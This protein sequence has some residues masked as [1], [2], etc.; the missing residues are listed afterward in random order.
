MKS[1]VHL[2]LYKILAISVIFAL[3]W[4]VGGM[5]AQAK[6][7]SYTVVAQRPNDIYAQCLNSGR[8]RTTLDAESGTLR[9]IGTTPGRP[10]PKPASLPANASPEAAAR[11]YLS[12]CGSLLG[13]RN[14]ASELSVIRQKADEQRTTVRFQ[15][16]Y[17]GIPIVGGEVIVQVDGNK[18]IVAVSKEILP[19]VQITTQASISAAQAQENALQAV[20]KKYELALSDLTASEPELWIYN[21]RL[22]GPDE[23][24]TRLVW[25]MEVEPVA[26]MPI[27]EFVLV[28]AQR[29]SV[30]LS[31]NQVDTAKNRQTYTANNTTTLPGTLVC[32]ESNPTCSGGDTHAQ[33]AHIY[34]GD[35]Y[36]FYNTYHGRDSIDN[37]GMTLKSTV[38]YDASYCNAFWNGNQMVYGDSCNLVVDDVVAHE[39][40]HG[41]TQY[42]SG[43]F[44]YYQSG[45]INESFSDLWGEFVDQTNGKGT[46]TPEVKW[47]LGEDSSIGAIRNMQNPPAFSDPDRMQ[48]THYY[49]GSD[50]NGGVHTNSGVNNKAVFLMTDGGS[51]NGKTVTA[52][53]LTKVATIYYEAQTNL[54]TSGADYKDLYDALYQACY[55]KTGVNGITTAD[56]QEIRDATD[57]VEM[58]LQPLG[59]NYNPEAPLCL[60]NEAPFNLFYDDMEYGTAN[61]SFGALVG[62]N[63]WL[64]DDMY[65]HSGQYSLYA[66]DFLQETSGTDTYAAMNASVTLPPN[67]FLHFS[68]AYGFEDGSGFTYDGGVLEYS[69]NNGTTWTDASSLFYDNGYNGTIDMRYSNPLA[70]RSAFVADSHGYIS[71][72]LYLNSLAGQSI[73]FRWRMG[74]DET[75]TDWGW[76]LDDVRIYTCGAPNAAPGKITDLS[77]ATGTADGTVDLTWT[78]PADD[79]AVTSYLVRYSTSPI[80]SEGSWWNNATPF[81]NSMT[82]KA[83]GQ[84]ET[85]TVT[86]LTPGTTYYFAVRARDANYFLGELSN[87]PS[88]VAAGTVGY[89][90]GTYDDMHEG[91]LYNGTWDSS[92]L[93]GPYQNTYHYSSVANGNAQFLINGDKFTLVYVGFNTAGNL[94]V[95]VDGGYLATIS[96]YNATTQWQKRWTSPSFGLGPHNIEFRHVSGTYISIDAIEVHGPLGKGIYDDM[97][98]GWLYTGTWGS[99]T[100]SGPYLNTYHYSSALNDTAQFV[101]NGD[102]FTLTY[103]SFNTAGDLEVYVDGDYLD[104]ISQYSAATQWQRTWTSPSLGNGVHGLK[105]VHKSGTYVSIDAIQVYGE[106]DAVPPGDI[107]DLAATT[108]ATNGSVNLTWTAPSDNI[109]VTAYQVKYSKTAINDE[110]DW[111]NATAVTSG[112]PMPGS[113]GTV[114]SMTVNGLPLGVTYYFAVRAQDATPNLSASWNTDD[115]AVKSP[116]ALGVGTYDDMH[117]G[118]LY[119]GTWGSSTLSGPYL[120]TYHYSSALNDTAQ[121]VMNGD[122]F[123]LT[124]VSFNTAG[125]LEV[126]VDGDY[127][128]TISQ[129]SAATQ[130]QRTWTSPSLGNGVHGLKFVHKSGTYVSIDA[131][132]ISE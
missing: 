47:L 130:W 38:H 104:T 105:F 128:D 49:L 102:K 17:Q 68:H 121:F 29:G 64:R 42:E 51:F 44:Y 6:D 98:S 84:T 129:Y 80:T 2:Y 16:Q 109:G 132:T 30:V 85:L 7:D 67:S 93:S 72:R 10:I 124:Y 37:A 108:G 115:A 94:D 23:G 60:N 20:A 62:T 21:P 99:S 19:K 91:W 106:P 54:L 87:V 66:D 73:R 107:T 41:V 83:A 28:D 131:I 52:L 97:H 123:T 57:A 90:P 112:I 45:A 26:L 1:Y 4:P 120:N 79:V 127:L 125:D 116:P 82:P 36:D 111:A 74:L 96:Q 103:V 110:T 9:F 117:S 75:G 13:L 15:Q 35:T 122:K 55:N 65:A 95:Y 25:R 92:T 33:N 70:G 86:G 39:M 22:I 88:A 31:F 71:S 78:A 101:M 126:Y 59:G 76:W 89:G 8:A 53:G 34:A 46:D 50:D 32:N 100:L 119:T 5:T 114:E 63:R 61:W 58:N 14:Q 77:A 113:A 118:W 27:R 40:T 56:C 69:L 12:V 81:P 18:N 48:S 3:L 11:G 43:L 24:D